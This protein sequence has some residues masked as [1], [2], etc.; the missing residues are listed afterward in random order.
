MATFLP[1]QSC[2]HKGLLPVEP[3]RPPFIGRNQEKAPIRR[4][5][6]K[7]C[8]SASGTSAA[9]HW[10]VHE[11]GGIWRVIQLCRALTGSMACQYL[12]WTGLLLDIFAGWKNLSI[13][14][15]L[16]LYDFALF[17]YMSNRIVM[18]N[19]SLLSPVVNPL[20][21]WWKMFRDVLPNVPTFLSLAGTNSTYCHYFVSHSLI[22]S[23][24]LIL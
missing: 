9:G 1:P 3:T 14:Q 17:V 23:C 15:A 22:S 16:Y 13:Y 10:E 6:C 20:V 18:C 11:G 5:E 4:E 19:V 8:Q 2:H 7:C 12:W 21:I 24:Q